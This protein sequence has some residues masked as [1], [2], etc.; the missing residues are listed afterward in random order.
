MGGDTR[1]KE[2]KA[3]AEIYKL[4]SIFQSVATALPWSVTYTFPQKYKLYPHIPF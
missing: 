1:R 3:Q 4:T 2:R